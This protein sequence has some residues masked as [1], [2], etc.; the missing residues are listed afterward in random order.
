MRSG[1]P[2][3]ENDGEPVSTQARRNRRR[4]GAESDEE[5]LGEDDGDALAWEILGEKA[6]FPNNR[7]PAVPGFLL[8]PLSVQKRV[9]A[10]QPRAARL[11]RDTQAPVTK[12]QE[13]QE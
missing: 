12:P 10:S 4:T 7:R 2:L 1:R 5:E 9:R 6:C 8:G 11:R 13:L 3:G